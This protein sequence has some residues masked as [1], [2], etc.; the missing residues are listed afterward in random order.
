L[1]VAR[2]CERAAAGPGKAWLCTG[3]ADN[4]I[5]GY[6]GSRRFSPSF[7]RYLG[8]ATQIEEALAMISLAIERCAIVAPLRICG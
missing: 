5:D 7:S 1:A 4:Q 6:T 2:S 3:T 8:A